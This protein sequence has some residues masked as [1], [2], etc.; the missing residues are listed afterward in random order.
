MPPPPNKF[1]TKSNIPANPVGAAGFAAGV[2]GVPPAL[3]VVPVVAEVVAGAAPVVGA[4][5]APP[6]DG[7]PPARDDAG[8]CAGACCGRPPDGDRDDDG[9]SCC[10]DCSPG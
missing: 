10:C 3:G 4:G 2:V 6:V 9:C 7:A 5:V 8:V 1:F